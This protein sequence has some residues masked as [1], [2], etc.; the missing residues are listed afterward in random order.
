MEELATT[1]ERKQ[2]IGYLRYLA[3]NALVN[4]PKAYLERMPTFNPKLVYAAL[5]SAAD[6][7]EQGIVDMADFS[8]EA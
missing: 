1:L 7:I 2:V 6:Q 5:M 4:T 8:G 3:K